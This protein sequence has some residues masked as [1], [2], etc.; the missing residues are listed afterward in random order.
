MKG[1]ACF[2]LPTWV[3]VTHAMD[4]DVTHGFA[5]PYAD[6]ISKVEAA[7][8][9]ICISKVNVNLNYTN[10]R[11]CHLPGSKLQLP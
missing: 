7:V 6:V 11:A 10:N 4:A 8:A 3:A 9:L 2:H 1:R 5:Y